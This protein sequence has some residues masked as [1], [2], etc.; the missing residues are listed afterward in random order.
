MESKVFEYRGDQQTPQY[1]KLNDPI[2][3]QGDFNTLVKFLKDNKCL[4]FDRLNIGR[5]IGAFQDGFL[6]LLNNNFLKSINF[7]CFANDSIQVIPGE[8]LDEFFDKEPNIL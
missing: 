8:K 5:D 2:L 7:L 4:S 3:N 1:G 6:Y